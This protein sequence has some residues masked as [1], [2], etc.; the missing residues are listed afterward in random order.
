[1]NTERRIR[2]GCII[3]VC[4]WLMAAGNACALTDPLSSVDP[5]PPGP[6]PVGCSN[7]AQN[8]R[9]GAR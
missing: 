5:R 9:L 3:A 8:F 4:A 7:V 6:Y 1:M 2:I